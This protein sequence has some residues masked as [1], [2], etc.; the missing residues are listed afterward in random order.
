MELNTHKSDLARKK[1]F[2]SHKM[3][4]NTQKWD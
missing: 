3:G 1:A 4:F 2:N